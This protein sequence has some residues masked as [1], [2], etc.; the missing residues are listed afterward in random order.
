MPKGFEDYFKSGRPKPK[1]MDG[2]NSPWDFTCPPYDQRSSGYIKAG[3][4]YGVGKPQ[5]VG[6]EGEAKEKVACLPF[7]RVD[8]RGLH[9]P[10]E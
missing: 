9:E 2:K 8:T 6:H 1:P 4:S 7:G 10:K 5:P 3:T